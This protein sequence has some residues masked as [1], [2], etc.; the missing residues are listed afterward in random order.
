MARDDALDVP[1]VL[2]ASPC[3]V[4]IVLA[5]SRA[6]GDHLPMSDT[7]FFVLV[8][9]TVSESLPR[10][11]E[12]MTHTRPVVQ[13]APRYVHDFGWSITCVYECGAIIQLN[14]NDRV[15]I[16]LNPMRARGEILYDPH[17]WC[18]AVKASAVKMDVDLATV[19]YS[20]EARLLVRL[21]F[22]VRALKKGEVLH[23]RTLLTE[24]IGLL[25]ALLRMRE[26]AFDARTHWAHPLKRLERDLPT[27]AGTLA[28]LCV[29]STARE[30]ATDAKTVLD[31]ALGVGLDLPVE[32]VRL[33]DREVNDG[34]TGCRD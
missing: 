18:E 26:G 9:P 30:G 3:V 32:F 13:L 29:G 16:P 25:A 15:S 34:A 1:A 33:V 7:D 8:T 23:A 27:V 24:C 22:S 14:V 12:L 2:A 19:R 20:I 31:L 21:L 11:A 4:G 6:R 17:A 10:V 5:G 28:G